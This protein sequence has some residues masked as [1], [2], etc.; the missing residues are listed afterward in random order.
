MKKIDRALSREYPPIVVNVEGLEDIERV[1][2]AKE[3]KVTIRCDDQLFESVGELAEHLKG[4]RVREVEITSSEPYTTIHLRQFSARLYVGSSNTSSSGL[5]FQLD[6]ILS[7]CRRLG[8]WAYS[9]TFVLVAN[10]VI[11]F[12]PYAVPTT[13]RSVVAISLSSPFLV[14]LAWFVFVINHRHS[15]VY[16][17]RRREERTFFQRNR[18]QLTVALFSAL[19]GALLGAT[20]T[21][22]V[23]NIVKSQ[24]NI[25]VERDAPK[26]PRPSP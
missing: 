8:S 12:L 10:V 14:W 20:A 1:L 4:T 6:Q 23:N 13:Y 17:V 22:V 11:W 25:P 7:R 16:I 3:D 15:T 19:I 26:A 5:F 18:D 24:P 21:Y 9:W 2:N